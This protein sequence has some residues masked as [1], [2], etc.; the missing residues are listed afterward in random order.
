MTLG[1]KMISQ[2]KKHRS[3]KQAMGNSF[4]L[5]LA[6][7]YSAQV[8]RQLAETDIR[9][10]PIFR[11]NL[12]KYS[13]PYFLHLYWGHHLL[14]NVSSS[15]LC[16]KDYSCIFIRSSFY[17]TWNLD[18]LLFTLMGPIVTLFCLY[19]YVIFIIFAHV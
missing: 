6:V 5:A 15:H 10:N 16:P 11:T 9:L 18:I 12:L 3:Y 1:S 17:T 8:A 14:R 7:L 19:L 2:I 4:I 13:C